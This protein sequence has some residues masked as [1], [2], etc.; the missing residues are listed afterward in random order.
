M[1]TFCQ[2]IRPTRLCMRMK[3]Y[4]CERFIVE[5]DYEQSEEL[6]CQKTQENVACVN[7]ISG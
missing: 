6:R 5:P 1:I 7:P 3:L 2:F 4:H